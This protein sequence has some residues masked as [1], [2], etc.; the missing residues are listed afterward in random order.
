MR[1]S[2]LQAVTGTLVTFVGTVL[3]TF[4]LLGQLPALFEYAAYPLIG[5]VIVAGIVVVSRILEGLEAA[6]SE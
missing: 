4:F 6:T 1:P 3:V 2:F 5:A